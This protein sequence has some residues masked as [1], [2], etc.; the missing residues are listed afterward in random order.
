MHFI[1]LS[2]FC[3]VLIVVEQIK[4]LTV[5]NEKNRTEF[6]CSHDLLGHT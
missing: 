1:W 6:R 5:C 3:G 4:K 2:G